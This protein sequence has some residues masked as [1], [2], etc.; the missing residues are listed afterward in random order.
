MAN[1]RHDKISGAKESAVF[2]TMPSELM[3]GFRKAVLGSAGLQAEVREARNAGDLVRIA[4]R[5]GFG[6]TEGEVQAFRSM[7]ARFLGEGEL[8]GTH[9]SAPCWCDPS[10]VNSKSCG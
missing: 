8:D 7:A 3:E 1:E 10:V 6:V 9:L 5:H 2:N 4:A